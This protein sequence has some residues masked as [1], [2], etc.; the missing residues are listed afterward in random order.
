[1][2][3]APPGSVAALLALARLNRLE[4]RILLCA[5]SGMSREDM[6]RA[7]ETI[8]DA[9]TKARYEALLSRR[10]DGEPIAYLTGEREFFGRPFAS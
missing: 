5:A 7:P 2:A 4:R 10:E 9:A 3:S 8:L 6:A 1:M